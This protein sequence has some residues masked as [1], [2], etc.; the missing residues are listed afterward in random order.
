MAR[1]QQAA[2]V[3]RIG[4]LRF[5]S[6]AGDANNVEALRAGLRALG[7][8]EGKNLVIEF[9]WAET[10]EQL[11]EAAAQLVRMNVDV[12][13]ALSSTYATETERARQAT[14]TIP[15]VFA[16]HADPVGLGHVASLSR[17]GGNITGLSVVQREFTAK[18]VEILKEAVPHA[19][20][21]G[22]LGTPTAPSGRP[23]L[24][25]A[26]ATGEKLGVQVKG[27]SVLAVADFAGAFATMAR[28]RV[29]AV[30]VHGSALTA[31]HNRPLLA[32]LALKH[33]LPSMFQVRA[34]VEAGGLMCY[35]PDH[36][37][38]TRRSAVYI[39]KI[40]KGAKPADLPVEQASKHELV[41]NFRTAKALGLA[42]PPSLLLRADHLIEQ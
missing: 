2:K 26:E 39:D 21:F 17:P 4:Y 9:R 3:W 33:R 11:Q 15:I 10:V 32:E 31:R 23:T 34:N 20:R 16:S 8:V 22:V 1:A 6:A 14:N 28:D 41:I 27:V 12:I 36:Q 24:R 38:L 7:H 18:S 35:T 40:L 30:L 13:F 42:I 29:G 5:S 37:D 25:A 19:T